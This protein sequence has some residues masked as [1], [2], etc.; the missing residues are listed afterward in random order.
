MKAKSEAEVTTYCC[1]Q[2]YETMGDFT[3]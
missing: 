3:F 1:Y 2:E